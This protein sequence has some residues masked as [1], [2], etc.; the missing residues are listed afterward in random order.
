MAELSSLEIRLITVLVSVLLSTLISVIIFR[1][2]TVLIDHKKINEARGRVLLFCSYLEALITNSPN[3]ADADE[4]LK[5][6]VQEYG[7]MYVIDNCL[8]D[9]YKILSSLYIFLKSGGY[10]GN[11]NRKEKDILMIKDIYSRNEEEL[12]RKYAGNRLLRSLFR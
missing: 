4:F 8:S 10:V 11:P 5:I 9:D 7:I 2:N 3:C 12:T 1:L 6:F